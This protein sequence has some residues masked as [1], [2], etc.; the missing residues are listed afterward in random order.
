MKPTTSSTIKYMYFDLDGTLLDSKKQLDPKLVQLILMIKKRFNIQCG[1]ATGRHF[2]MIQYELNQLQTELPTVCN[3]GANVIYN[4]NKRVN[5]NVIDA[6]EAS[7]IIDHLLAK[8]AYFLVYTDQ[9]LYTSS[10]SNPRILFLAEQNKA[11]KLENWMWQYHLV[12]KEK[13]A[14]EAVL[15]FLLCDKN[16]QMAF[17]QWISE[18]FP[19]LVSCSSE[20]GLFDVNSNGTDKFYAL[21]QVLEQLQ[22]NPDEV[23]FFGDNHNDLMCLKNLKHSVCV[24]NHHQGLN[25]AA[26][27]VAPSADECGVYQFLVSF[28]QLNNA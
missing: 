8:N 2:D 1:I 7:Q 3:N 15:K 13:I 21:E 25:D 26:T 28:F 22:I 23:L 4:Q 18:Q 24:G 14:H 16:Y 20:R 12:D 9:H 11:Q 17:E 10:W 19:H 6:N 27:Y 5:L